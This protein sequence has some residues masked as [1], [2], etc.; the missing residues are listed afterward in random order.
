MTNGPDVGKLTQII[1]NFDDSLE[2]TLAELKQ[3]NNI[4]GYY[5]IHGILNALN[6]INLHACSQSQCPGC[7][8]LPPT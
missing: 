4:T 6:Y 2:T 5:I 7:N 8:F 1:I 3:H